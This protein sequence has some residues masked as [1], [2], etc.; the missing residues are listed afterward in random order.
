[1]RPAAS[2]ATRRRPPRLLATPDCN[3]AGVGVPR[4]WNSVATTSALM[5]VGAGLLRLPADA[6]SVNTSPSAEAW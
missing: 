3:V 6:A 5:A 1:M 2:T 4:N